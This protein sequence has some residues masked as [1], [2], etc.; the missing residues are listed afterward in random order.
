MTSSGIQ[1]KLP[2][3]ISLPIFNGDVTDWPT[4]WDSFEV[5]VHKNAALSEVEKLTYLRSL[6]SKGALYQ[7]WLL[8]PRTMEKQLHCWSRGMAVKSA[9]FQGAFQHRIC[10]VAR[11]Y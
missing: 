2:K 1:A 4:F 11:Q 8:L 5:A 6:V 7:D 10:D 9:L 3:L